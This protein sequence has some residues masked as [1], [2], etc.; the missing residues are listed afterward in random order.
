MCQDN[1]VEDPRYQLCLVYGHFQLGQ[2]QFFLLKLM[3][4][5]SDTCSKR[6][7]C[8]LLMFCNLQQPHQILPSLKW[9]P[10]IFC[11]FIT[12]DVYFHILQKI[13]FYYLNEIFIP[14]LSNKM[15]D[16]KFNLLTIFSRH[17]LSGVTLPKYEALL[18]RNFS[19]S[20]NS[21][22]ICTYHE[23]QVNGLLIFLWLRHFEHMY[24]SQEI[25]KLL[26]I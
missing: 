1:S 16:I 18:L 3:L 22:R 19:Q 25:C 4:F 15:V 17:F 23:A 8:L 20:I 26:L 7:F 6:W 13:I 9:A 12:F 2:L 5:Q 24:K 11:Q 14:C 10:N 21:E